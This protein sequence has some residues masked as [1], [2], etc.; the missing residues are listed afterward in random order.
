M[1]DHVVQ[2]S[3]DMK[4]VISSVDTRLNVLW[5]HFAMDI[6]QDVPLLLPKE[7]KLNAMEELKSVG[8]ERVLVPF[9]KSMNWKS[10][11]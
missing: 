6:E 8:Q 5:S 11:S 10:V 7:T 3:A 9:V 1:K 4:Q 2:K